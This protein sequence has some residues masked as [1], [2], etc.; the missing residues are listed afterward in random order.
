MTNL[1][2]QP[3]ARRPELVSWSAP[4]NGRHLVRNRHT[5]ESFQ[6]GEEERFL[7]AQLDGRQ[8]AEEIREAY[9]RH[10]DQPLSDEDL[11]QFIELATQ[12]GLGRMMILSEQYMYTGR[13]IIIAFLY[14]IFSIGL[15][16]VYVQGA[17]YITRWVPRVEEIREGR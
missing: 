2:T 7:L 14:M 6:L 11:D 8:A 9:A 5:G 17:N 13:M 12:R 10:F 4:D 3:A 16:K 15:N 1:A